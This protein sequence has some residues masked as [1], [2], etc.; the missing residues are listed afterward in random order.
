[1]IQ[2]YCL[3]EYCQILYMDDCLDGFYLFIIHTDITMVIFLFT[4]LILHITSFEI[5]LRL[6]SKYISEFRLLNDSNYKWQHL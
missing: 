1:M 4:S 6:F 3:K 5:N 2:F